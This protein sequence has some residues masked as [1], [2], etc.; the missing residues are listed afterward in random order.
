MTMSQRLLTLNEIVDSWLVGARF[1]LTGL[2]L[3]IMAWAIAD[4]AEVLQTAPYLISILGDQISPQLLPGIV[5]LLAASTA[6]ASGSSWGVMAILMPLVIPLCWAVLLANGM[7]TPEHMHILYSC[8]ACVL[9]GAVWADHCSP[10]S[11]TTVLSSL[12][13]GCDHMEHV[14]TQLPYAALGGVVAFAIGVVPAGYGQPWWILLPAGAGVLYVI[15][16]FLGKTVPESVT[17]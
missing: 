17:E 16:R 8:I 1:M 10:I 11:D 15:H 3:L 14:R 4:V 2:V 12:A 13:T 9:T 7:A 5:F 6:F